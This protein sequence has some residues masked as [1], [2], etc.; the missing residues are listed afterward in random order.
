MKTLLFLTNFSPLAP[1]AADYAYKL[2]KQLKLKMLICNAVT[3]ATHIPQAGFLNLPSEYWDALLNNS[4]EQLKQLKKQLEHSDH[5]DGFHPI[6]NCTNGLGSVSDVVEQVSGRHQVALVVMSANGISRINEIKLPLLLV[7]A[8]AAPVR[9][10]KIAFA[11][12]FL[13]QEQDLENIYKLIPFARS[14]DAEILLVH[15]F[16]ENDAA[17]CAWDK[18][19]LNKISNKAN[20]PNI[21]YR[22]IIKTIQS[23]V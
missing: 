20:Y 14:L 18:E 22:N 4:T 3:P 10:K 7:P 17:N 16:K 6:V 9:I 23:K 2:A 11:S 19:F 1:Q 8:T 12:D 13:D 15:V 21:F 5:S